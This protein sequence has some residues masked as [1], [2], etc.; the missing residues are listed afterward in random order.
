MSAN[1]PE[2]LYSLLPS[3]Y[4]LRDAE[5]RGELR[6]LLAV[7]EAELRVIERDVEGL[8][9]NW[10]VE[11]CDE[12]AVPYLGDLL[13][14]R[15]PG[16]GP[17][18]TESPDTPSFSR[19][20]YVANTLAYRRRKGTVPVLEQ[21]ARDITGWPAR[22]VEFFGLLGTTQHMNHVRPANAAAALR[23]ANELELVGSPFER[24]PRT[25]EVRRIVTNRG[26]YNIPNIGLYL[27]RLRA[28]PAVRVPAAPVEGHAG[29]Y[30][31]DPLGRDVPLF[32]R[33]QAEL[34]ISHLA[35]EANVPGP[36]RRRA[37]HRELESLRQAQ[38]E[39]RAPRL[40]LFG[41]Q[42]VWQVFLDGSG[43]PVPPE[44][45]VV[46]HLGEFGRPPATKTYRNARGEESNLPI[47]VAVDPLLGR[48]ALAQGEADTG[49]DGRPRRVH[50]SHSY[51]FS[52]ELGGGFYGRH[53]SGEAR[54]ATPV[55]VTF[56]PTRD[57]L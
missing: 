5:G 35:D 43:T 7:I 44:H 32:R 30:R 34:D 50:V 31:F 29:G 8:Y 28:Y 49:A 56:D 6:A 45:T 57:A 15:L 3:I 46:C 26:R 33:P 10:F 36:L 13:G 55:R 24:V 20:A 17:Q 48:L 2:R 4:R 40:S 21:L 47:V 41:R 1:A 11:T 16:L 9:D 42:P 38:V 23:H 27:W 37:A 12:W 51:G 39:G 54:D 25:A 14:V 53:L 19:R 18:D 52:S 22:A